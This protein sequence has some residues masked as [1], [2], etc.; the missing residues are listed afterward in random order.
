[1]I[2][3]V[4]SFLIKEPFQAI[5]LFLEN[6][7]FRELRKFALSDAEWMALDAFREILEVRA[8]QQYISQLFIKSNK[9]PHAFQQILSFEST[10]TLCD[11]L[12]AYSAFESAWKEYQDIHPEVAPFIEHGLDKL[13]IYRARTELVPAYVLAMSKP[14]Y[15]THKYLRVDLIFT[16]LSTPRRS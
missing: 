14:Y 3:S 9:I 10:P 6:D 13:E 8:L 12:P 15:L 11:A 4:T 2:Y 5:T 16:Q 1:M 7:V